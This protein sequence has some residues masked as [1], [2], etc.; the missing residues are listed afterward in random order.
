M[1]DH[2]GSYRRDPKWNGFPKGDWAVWKC[3][4]GAVN[5]CTSAP[6]K[7]YGTEKDR[8]F[9]RSAIFVS[10]IGY[11]HHELRC[12]IFQTRITEK[13]ELS[14]QFFTRIPCQTAEA[15]IR[16][17]EM[18]AWKSRRVT[19]SLDFEWGS[20]FVGGPRSETPCDQVLFGDPCSRKGLSELSWS[21]K[22]KKYG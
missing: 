19:I 14:F 9:Q 22:K 13:K 10:P 20:M 8:R 11:V 17:I 3:L 12:R 6:F 1:S 21:T 15:Q 4:N 7:V 16:T 2:L 18:S 5:M